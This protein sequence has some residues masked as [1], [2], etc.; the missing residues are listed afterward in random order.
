MFLF[1]ISYFIKLLLSYG[2]FAV[3]PNSD[4][5]EQRIHWAVKSR[6]E[7][8]DGATLISWSRGKPLAWYVSVPDTY[9]ASYIHAK[10]ISAG[11]AV[12]KSATNKTTK[13]SNL[14]ATRLFTPIAL[15][16][17]GVWCSKSAQFIV[18]LGKRTTAIINEI[19]RDDIPLPQT[20]RASTERQCG[21]LPQHIP[22]VINFYQAQSI[23]VGTHY[24]TN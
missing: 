6:R 12:E 14:S 2:Y 10:A 19:T 1:P 24:P 21:R 5:G 8:T 20:V 4:P 11:A 3:S 17:N 16:T 23:C 13:Y 7:E 9:A 22:R 15:D 18:E